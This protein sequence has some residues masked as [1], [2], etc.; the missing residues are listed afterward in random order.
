[1]REKRKNRDED[2]VGA[3]TPDVNKKGTAA[4]IFAGPPF[5]FYDCEDTKIGSISI[6]V[7]LRV[8]LQG[9]FPGEVRHQSDLY[10]L[11]MMPAYRRMMTFRFILREGVTSP[12]SSVNGSHM[13]VN[14]RTFSKRGRSA[15]AS[16]IRDS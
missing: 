3:G 5:F 13:S 6:R 14:F 7:I 1:M 8:M 11:S 15:W 2:T 10:I 12:L 4:R 9:V 16:S